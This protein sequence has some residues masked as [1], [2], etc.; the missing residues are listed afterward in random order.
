MVAGGRG[1]APLRPAAAGGAGAP[2]GALWKQRYREAV[3][4]MDSDMQALWSALESRGRLDKTVIVVVADHGES[5]NDHG[6]LLHGDAFFDGVINV[7]LMIRVPGI[8]GGKASSA[9]VSQVE[10]WKAI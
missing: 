8:P 10:K 9:L 7:P 3:E 1:P 4:R 5:L 6:E 2:A